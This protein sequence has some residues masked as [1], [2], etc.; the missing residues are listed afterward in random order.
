MRARLSYAALDAGYKNPHKTICIPKL[1]YIAL[2]LFR[3][4]ACHFH[5][6][7]YFFSYDLDI[8]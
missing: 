1:V 8:F 3:I 5:I 6:I 4:Y 2:R 7:L